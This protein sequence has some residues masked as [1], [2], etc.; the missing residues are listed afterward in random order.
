MI[1]Q[2]QEIWRWH[3]LVKKVWMWLAASVFI[4]AVKM[5]LIGQ[6]Q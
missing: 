2:K 1:F 6:L 5:E 4:L 3:G